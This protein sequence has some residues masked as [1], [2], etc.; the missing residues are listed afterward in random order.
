MATLTTTE[1]GASMIFQSQGDMMFSAAKLQSAGDIDLQSQGN[2]KFTAQT[3]RWQETITFGRKNVLHQAREEDLG[4]ALNAQGS[5][6]V[7][8]GGDIAGR[9]V[10]L[11]AQD[12][13]SLRAQGAITFEAGQI[14]TT[15]DDQWYSRNSGFLSSSESAFKLHEDARR[16]QPSTITGETVQMWAG[17]DLR[18][19]GSNVG[20]QRDLTLAAQQQVAITPAIDTVEAWVYEQTKQSGFGALGGLSYGQRKQTDRGQSVQTQA[21]SSLVG[22]VEGDVRIHAGEALAVVGSRVLALEGD[23]TLTGKEVT[24]EAARNTL[25]EQESHAIK[26]SGLTVTANTPVINALQVGQRMGRAVGQLGGAADNPV[27]TALAGVTTGLAAKN[28]YDAVMKD[29]QHLGG[30]SVVLSVG[31]SQSRSETERISSWVQGS[32]VAAGEDLTVLAQGAGQDSDLTVTGSTLSAGQTLALVAEGDIL[33]QAAPNQAQQHTKS[34]SSSASIGLGVSVGQRTDITV[35]LGA[36]AA[37]GNADGQD[38]RWTNSQVTAGQTLVMNTG[39]DLTLKGAQAEGEHIVAKVGGDLWLE[40]LQ[41]THTYR[42]KQDSQGVSASVCLPPLC[43]GASSVA[44]NVGHGKMKSDFRSVTAQSG[45]HAGDGGFR[46]DVKDH[47]QLAG[48]VIAS[49]DQAVTQGRNQLA[50]GTLST[51]DIENQAQYS[52]SQVS[53]GAGFT[54]GGQPSD[55]GTTKDGQV[56]GGAS[57][58]HGS[59]IPTSKDGLGVGMPMVAAAS[60]ERHSTTQSA[61]S[62]GTIVIR[63][64]AA[65]Q[66][67]TGMTPDETIARLKRETSSTENALKPIFDQEKIEAGF[68]IVAEATRQVAQFFNNRAQ[69]QKALEKALSDAFVPNSGANAAQVNTLL[70]EL[71]RAQ[72]WS[73]TGKYGQVMLAVTGAAAGNVAASS[74]AFMQAAAVNYLQGLGASGVKQIADQLGQGPQAEAARAALHSIVGCAGAAGQGAACASGALGAGAGSILN[75]LMGP[76]SELTPQQAEARRNTVLSLVAGIAAS[77]GMSAAT[78]STAAS[79]ETANNWGGLP[80]QALSVITA[81]TAKCATYA[82]CQRA[83]TY[84]SDKR[85]YVAVQMKDGALYVGSAALVGM[86][87]ASDP[88]RIKPGLNLFLIKDWVSEFVG[89]ITHGP[90]LPGKPGEVVHVATPPLPA[91]QDRFGSEIP[92]WPGE[93]IGPIAVPGQENKGPAT[94]MTT[95]TPLLE[96]QGPGLIFSER[97]GALNS[98]AGNDVNLA[99]PDRTNHILNGDA[100]GGG[101]LWPG[102]PGKSAFPENWSASEIM[103]AVSDIATDPSIPETVQSNG[104]IVKDRMINGVNIRVVIES[105]N[106]GGG[107]VTAFPTNVPR[108]PK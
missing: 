86:A 43:M 42:S 50:T 13:L 52:A 27:M 51:E 95:E 101:H 96:P 62:G 64:E 40:S 44:V 54:W 88:I 107:I 30:A 74:G 21:A 73:A 2:V 60:G 16:A 97:D 58:E 53:L 26:Q 71:E 11:V 85:M 65:Q 36:S 56:A 22:S 108:N 78:A 6:V 23:V 17:E 79:L 81:A 82:G 25:H 34:R 94:G 5:I 1:A 93:P 31:S 24:I 14:H 91:A 83:V 3:E 106:K 28:A 104:R 9:A 10:N 75:S 72:Q 45:L 32:T 90:T 69:E 68:E 76:A 55:L 38:T 63:N 87:A 29:P 80:G 33:L 89:E 39:N 8:A 92:V 61:I 35:E 99:L 49:S 4:S 48:A 66:D 19:T 12:D 41:D 20:G 15:L 70:D 105:P 77:A 7:E 67:L 103:N 102:V 59:S 57:K 100:T 47:T 46:I 84:R 18:L 98:G 37:R